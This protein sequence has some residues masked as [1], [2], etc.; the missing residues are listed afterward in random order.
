MT[1]GAY[2]GGN[3]LKIGDGGGTEAFT[4]IGE[5]QSVSGIGQTNQE[6]RVTHWGSTGHE[7][8]ASLAEGSQTTIVCNTVLLNTE[9]LAAITDVKAAE[10]ARNFEFVTTD[11]TTVRTGSFAMA[12]LGYEYNPSTGE[13][14]EQNQLTISG[15]IS[16]DITWVDT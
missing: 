3:T 13:Q 12:M 14:G 4:A 2:A 8:I 15:R 7:Y 11:G 10:S 6:I 16:G 1:T 9:Q 5:V